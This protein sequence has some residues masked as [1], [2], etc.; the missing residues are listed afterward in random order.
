MLKSQALHRIGE[1]D[2][3]AQIVG[4]QLELVVRPERL[5][6]ADIHDQA[7]DSPIDFQFPVPVLLRAGFKRDHRGSRLRNSE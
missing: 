2:V 6:L 5:I 7:G 4:I 3:N 1:L